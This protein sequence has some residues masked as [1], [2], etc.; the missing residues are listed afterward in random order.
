MYQANI[1]EKR[2]DGT[3]RQLA[4]GPRMDQAEPVAQ[5]CEQINKAVA[6]GKEKKWVNARVEKVN[7]IEE[8]T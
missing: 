2:E 1:T 6:T 5:F 4:V 3:E 7:Q 8:H